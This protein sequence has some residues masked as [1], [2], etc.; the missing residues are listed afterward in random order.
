MKVRKA[1]RRAKAQPAID[2]AENA[3]N[4]C[5]HQLDK[6]LAV[7]A[8]VD[9]KFHNGNAASSIASVCD[10]HFAVILARQQAQEAT[11]RLRDMDWSGGG[12][13]VQS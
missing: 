11:D 12:K 5:V 2:Q 4:D 13:A 1:K 3:V 9:E 6:P 7:L 8:L 10:A